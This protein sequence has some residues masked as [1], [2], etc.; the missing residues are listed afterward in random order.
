MEPRKAG[1]LDLDDADHEA[2]CIATDRSPP[3]KTEWWAYMCEPCFEL[4][5]VA[6]GTG[7]RSEI[8]TETEDDAM[9]KAFI[10]KR[11]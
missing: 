11:L 1:L 10:G 8:E 5:E 7:L 9:L 2:Q 4:V 3:Q 6:L